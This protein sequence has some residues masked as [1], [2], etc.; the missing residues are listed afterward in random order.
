MNNVVFFSIQKF[1]A[2]VRKYKKFY[3][4]D[5]VRTTKQFIDFEDEEL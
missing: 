1:K 2:Y 5:V 3:A 4:V